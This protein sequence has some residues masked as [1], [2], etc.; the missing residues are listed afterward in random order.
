MPVHSHSCTNLPGCLSVLFC[1]VLTSVGQVCQTGGEEHTLEYL[2]SIT[3][4]TV[5]ESVEVGRY[6]IEYVPGKMIVA[7]I[8]TKG[9]AAA[10]HAELASIIMNC[11]F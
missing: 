4:R 6:T 7:D 9:L 8:M 3:Y 5:E 1:C 10:K 2:Y 11:K